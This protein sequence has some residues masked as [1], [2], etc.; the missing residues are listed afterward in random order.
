MPIFI[1]IQY[2]TNRIQFWEDKMINLQTGEL[3]FNGVI[4]NPWTTLED[5]ECYN[6]K[7][8]IFLRGNG[9]GIIRVV[10]QI[11]SNGV[12]A[13]VKI[14]INENIKTK[15]VIITP[16]LNKEQN[17]DLLQASKLWLKGQMSDRYNKDENSIRGEYS[18]GYISAQY[19]NDECYGLTGGEIIIDYRFGI[20]PIDYGNQ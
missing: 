14:E 3:E 15:R 12:N 13:K 9:R 7:V 5:Y 1:H 6:N 16:M 17:C 20:F 18:M 8:D 2:T 19:V 4:I 11:S 10:N